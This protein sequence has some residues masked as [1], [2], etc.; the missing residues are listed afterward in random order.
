MEAM[1]C[2]T[3]VIAFPSGALPEI[4]EHGR[5]GFLVGDEQEMADAIQLV[6]TIDPQV[7]RHTAERRFDVRRTCRQYLQLYRLLARDRQPLPEQGLI[8]AAD[9]ESAWSFR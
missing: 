6:D 4:V 7:C 2:G 1:A 8:Q 9:E 3:P 5:T